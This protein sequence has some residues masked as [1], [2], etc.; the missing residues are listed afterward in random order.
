MEFAIF[1]PVYSI[2]AVP[3]AADGTAAYHGGFYLRIQLRHPTSS[4]A[5][6]SDRLAA[7]QWDEILFVPIGFGQR[8]RNILIGFIQQ[9]VVCGDATVGMGLAPSVC[10]SRGGR[11]F[12]S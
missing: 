8:F 9:I 4:F 5:L 6:C 12:V 3:N 2:Q 10:A 11:W 7:A 1:H